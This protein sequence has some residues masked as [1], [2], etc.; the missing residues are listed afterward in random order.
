[1]LDPKLE[2]LLAVAEHRN[3]T[4]A[5]QALGL[6]QP[7][8]S[9][10]IGLLEKQLGIKLFLRGNSAF[11]LT[12]EGEIAVRYALRL[13]ALYQ[14]MCRDLR[15][16]RRQMTH[17]RVGLTHT[18]ESNT[19]TEMLARY[20]TLNNHVSITIIT[21][22]IKNLYARLANFE[23]DIAVVEGTRL[24]GAFNYLALDTDCLVCVLDN[25]NPLAR[26]AQ[27]TLEELKAQN[28]ILRLPS[29]ATRQLFEATLTSVGE[30]IEDFN[31]SIEVDNISTIKDLV[32]KGMGISILPQ[33]ACMNE[34]RKKK[35][36]A[37]PIE[38]LNMTR[39][40]S[41]VY[42][43]DFLRLDILHD[44]VELYRAGVQL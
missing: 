26:H 38:N 16:R 14:A 1:M 24:P 12:P 35:L 36:T 5:A 4:R 39:E 9:H 43:K 30:T 7:A 10:H 34:L 6:T 37:L 20:S 2:T 23:I 28:M 21:D 27:V 17:I 25:D 22:T 15:D 19:I 13:K 3:F 11:E 29:S 42:G 33:S 31:I 32:R 44:I 18:S 41:L 40:I 8:V